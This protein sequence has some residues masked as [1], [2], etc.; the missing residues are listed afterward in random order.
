[1]AMNAHDRVKLL[2]G[3]YHSARLRKGDRATCLLLCV[4]KHG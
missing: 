1:M 3:P 4:T 2:F